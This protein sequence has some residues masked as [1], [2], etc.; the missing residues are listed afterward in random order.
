MKR[1]LL[2]M[3]IDTFLTDMI[4]IRVNVRRDIIQEKYGR[5]IS[6]REIDSNNK[7]IVAAVFA[8]KNTKAKNFITKK[9]TTS[10]V[11]ALGFL[12]SKSLLFGDDWEI[13]AYLSSLFSIG[14]DFLLDKYGSQIQTVVE[15]FPPLRMLQEHKKHLGYFPS[16]DQI[17]EYLKSATYYNTDGAKWWIFYKC[18]EFLK[19][20]Y[21]SK[22]S[23]IEDFKEFDLESFILN[24]LK[25]KILQIAYSPDVVA[26]DNIYESRLEILNFLSNYIE[27]I[28]NYSWYMN[29]TKLV[30][31]GEYS[32]DYMIQEQLKL[33][34]VY[35]E[36][37]VN[38]TSVYEDFSY[39]DIVNVE[40]VWSV[41]YYKQVENDFEEYLISKG[42][43]SI[44][45]GY[46]DDESVTAWR[47]RTA[48]LREDFSRE[49]AY[50]YISKVEIEGDIKKLLERYGFKYVDKSS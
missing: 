50:N 31:S 11:D 32:A 9:V 37:I 41:F 20:T 33:L 25:E 22:I 42:H 16:T 18:K 24:E 7:G 17:T 19:E 30:V 3:D 35:N 44:P 28:E 45:Q 34:S 26:L 10:F 23:G 15:L 5:K 21:S 38:Y 40:T 6:N 36:Y 4:S 46:R 43:A 47:Q 8:N 48:N 13:D 27:G 29:D 39:E 1:F 49:Y 2:I 12:S 14:Y